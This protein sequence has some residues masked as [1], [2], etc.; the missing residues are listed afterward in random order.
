MKNIK[1]ISMFL[2]LNIN[3]T[4]Y[5]C[6]YHNLD[7]IM[8]D[9]RHYSNKSFLEDWA[10]EFGLD[11]KEDFKDDE[12]DENGEYIDGFNMTLIYGIDFLDG[13]FLNLDFIVS[14]YASGHPEY[15]NYEH[16][17]MA[18][19]FVQLSKSGEIQWDTDDLERRMKK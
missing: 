4:G 11:F 5:D 14:D 19:E 10:K 8:G 18:H 9:F 6:E 15:E 7:R 1:A 13:S 17:T 3:G 12:F 16:G 2:D